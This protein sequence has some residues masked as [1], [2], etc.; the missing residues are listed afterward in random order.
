MKRCF[1]EDK[2]V[3][4]MILIKKFV[5]QINALMV[6]ILLK[7]DVVK[8]MNIHSMMDVLKRKLFLIYVIIMI[9]QLIHVKV[10]ILDTLLLMVTV[11]N[12]EVYMINLMEYVLKNQLIVRHF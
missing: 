7:I 5:Q 8:Q 10:V 11:V 12:M 6:I 1:I 4:F 9:P 3:K 2:I